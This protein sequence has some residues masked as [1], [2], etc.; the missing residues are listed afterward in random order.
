MSYLLIA[1]YRLWA[2]DLFQL[3]AQYSLPL[4]EADAQQHRAQLNAQVFF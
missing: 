2:W 1:G 3:R 4:Q